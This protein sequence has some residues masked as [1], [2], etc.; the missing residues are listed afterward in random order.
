ML[1]V[2]QSKFHTWKCRYCGMSINKREKHMRE[3]HGILDE[4]EFRS[5]IE[6]TFIKNNFNNPDIKK[7]TKP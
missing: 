4:E 7:I 6:D 1:K 3:D 2:Q 5:E